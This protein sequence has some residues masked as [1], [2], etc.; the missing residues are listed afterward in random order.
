LGENL[1]ILLRVLIHAI[2]VAVGIIVSILAIVAIILALGGTGGFTADPP[3][4][5][6]GYLAAVLVIMVWAVIE[7]GLYFGWTRLIRAID[8]L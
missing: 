7:G 5:Q 8:A 1:I 2:A 3:P 6:P 4:D